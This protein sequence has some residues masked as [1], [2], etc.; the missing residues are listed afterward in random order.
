M[1]RVTMLAMHTDGLITLPPLERRQY[2]PRPIVYGQDTEVP[3]L[4]A[5]TTLDQGR[6]LELRTAVHATRPGTLWNEFVARYHD[7]GFKT[8]VGAQMR[9]A[10]HDKNGWPLGS[11][12]VPPPGRSPRAT[13]SSDGRPRYA[14]RTS[15]PSSLTTPGSPSCPGSGSPTRDRT[16][17]HSS[18]G[19]CPATGPGA[20]TPPPS[21]SRRSSKSRALPASSTGPQLGSM[22]KPP[23]D[24]GATTPTT[25]PANPKWTSGSGPSPNAGNAFS[26]G[27]LPRHGTTER[28]EVLATDGRDAAP[29]PHTPNEAQRP[30]EGVEA[31]PGTVAA[32]PGLPTDGGD[33]GPEGRDASVAST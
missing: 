32:D 6:P 12:S 21:S 14:R 26:T 15:P 29:R 5:P 28:L 8:R 31:K 18:A 19:A 11:A 16:S 2:R 27:R 30:L 25:K 24:A 13:A 9:Y 10:V 22:S 23:G 7:P 33:D 3:L 17:S 1:A 20:T 4:P